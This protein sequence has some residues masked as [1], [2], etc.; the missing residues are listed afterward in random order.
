MAL[1]LSNLANPMD[2][3]IVSMARESG[4]RLLGYRNQQAY[5]LREAH[6]VALFQAF[7]QDPSSSME[8]VS[9]ML[10]ICIAW[11]ACLRWDDVCDTEFGDM[12]WTDEYVKIL[13]INTKTD[14]YKSGQWCI[15]LVST[16]AHSAYQLLVRVIT[17]LCDSPEFRSSGK[18]V[19]EAPVAMVFRSEGQRRVPDPTRRLTYDLVNKRLKLWCEAVGLNPKLFTTHSFKRGGINERLDRGVP[20]RITRIDGRWRSEA[21]F[22]GYC[23]DEIQLVQRVEALRVLRPK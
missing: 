18:T 9:F 7:C 6:I 5:P 20:D 15:I 1:R 13:L 4:R 12:I 11:E 2:H 22:Q 14:T 21:S 19:A 23:D 8:D 10:L 17:Y 3:I 16:L